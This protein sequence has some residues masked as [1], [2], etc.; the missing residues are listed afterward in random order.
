MLPH[1][2]QD[3]WCHRR[4][5][6]LFLSQ[7]YSVLTITGLCSSLTRWTTI[8]PSFSSCHI[9]SR[10]S[11]TRSFCVSIERLSIFCSTQAVATRASTG[12]SFGP[13][14]SGPWPV[15]RSPHLSVMHFSLACGRQRG[16]GNGGLH[17][18]GTEVH[19]GGTEE[20]P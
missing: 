18:R 15:N 8:S 5:V 3:L 12:E 11:S 16:N 20:N 13:C 2:P 10:T 7:P 6:G 17:H 4:V 14:H 1:W 19:R 9:A